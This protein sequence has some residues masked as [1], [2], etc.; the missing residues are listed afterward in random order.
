MTESKAEKTE[1]RLLAYAKAEFMEM[2]YAG[3]NMRT[4][5]QKAGMTTGAI[6]RYFHDKNALF[7]ALVGP[8]ADEIMQ[9]FEKLARFQLK[10][11]EQN[12]K[13]E[14]LAESSDGLLQVVDFIFSRFEVF[15]LL[16]N[17]SA[18]SAW[19]NYMDSLIEH[20]LAST[21]AYLE[22]MVQMNLLAQT[23]LPRHLA[24]LVKQSYKQVLEI[25][26]SQMS[27]EEALEYMQ[28]LIPF[29]YAGWSTILRKNTSEEE[30][31]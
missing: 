11:L 3:A 21:Q 26:A 28:L 27:R 25:V 16:I 22:K 19:E 24:I 6:Y 18:G 17:R 23:P 29:L 7:A 10:M 30:A 1:K 2:G 20:D 5:A 8:T 14:E 4:I 31:T 9:H 12:N 15:D 13:I